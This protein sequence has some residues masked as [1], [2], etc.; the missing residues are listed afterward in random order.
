M[1]DIVRFDHV[2]QAVLELGPQVEFLERVFGFRVGERFENED[3][4]SGVHML[5]PGTSGIGWE[6]IAPSNATSPLHRFLEGPTGAGLHHVTIHV[7]D[8]VQAAAALRAEGAQ[9]WAGGLTEVGREPE[10]I[11]I[12]PRG[13][14]HGFLYQL[15]EGDPWHPGSGVADLDDRTI[16][17]KALNH[18]SHAYSGCDELGDW[19]ERL[20]GMETIHRS[21]GDGS[22]AGFRTRV[23]EHPTRQLRFEVIEPASAASFIQ[24]FL[25]RR[26]P[27]MHHA[28]F[29]VGDWERAVSACAFHN[30]PIFGERADHT[31]GVPWREAFIHPRH[32]GGVLVQFF[33]QAQEGA[34]I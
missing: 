34:W 31:D 3:G 20:F 21:P 4:Y 6:V 10:V 11:Y 23:L 15:Y 17:I 28:T 9:P 8:T 24:R 30:I 14:G 26:G 16:G 5:M 19:Y 1:I 27:G 18:L 2:S 7:R 22:E 29:E 25:E 12:H 13:G 32:T 33:W